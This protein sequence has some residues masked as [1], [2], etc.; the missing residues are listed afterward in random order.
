MT[1]DLEAALATIDKYMHGDAQQD[2]AETALDTL[3]AAL[4]EM[5]GRVCGTCRRSVRYMDYGILYCDLLR[6]ATSDTPCQLVGNAC[7]AWAAKETK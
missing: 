5:R 6:S 1:D 4:A 2:E 3:A 7:G